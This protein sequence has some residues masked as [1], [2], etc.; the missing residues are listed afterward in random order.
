MSVVAY[1]LRNRF[2]SVKRSPNLCG[3]IVCSEAEPLVVRLRQ[4][5][6]VTDIIEHDS[7]LSSNCVLI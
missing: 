7:P 6:H 1:G 5:L 4:V 2:L 3:L